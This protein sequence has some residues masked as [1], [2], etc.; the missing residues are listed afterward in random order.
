MLAILPP[1]PTVRP[2]ALLQITGPQSPKST[3]LPFGVDVV[4]SLSPSHPCVQASPGDPSD[5][6]QVGLNVGMA[7]EC[8]NWTGLS[9]W[10]TK[11]NRASRIVVGWTA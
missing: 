4:S 7:W 6:N 11:V 1:T 5:G 9:V 3:R 8:G 10:P 2:E